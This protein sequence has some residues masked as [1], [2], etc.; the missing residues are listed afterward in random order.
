MGSLRTDVYVGMDMELGMD[1]DVSMDMDLGMDMDMGTHLPDGC[2]RDQRVATDATRGRVK[3]PIAVLGRTA[4]EGVLWDV[5][6]QLTPTNHSDGTSR[7]L[8]VSE[9]PA[10][11]R[12][13]H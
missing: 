12:A 9:D 4:E 2:D 13:E 10:G 6:R 8:E 7:S 3:R 11:S 5:T 1:M